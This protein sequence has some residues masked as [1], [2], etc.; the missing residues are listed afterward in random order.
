[1]TA[2]VLLCSVLGLLQPWN[3][4]E[5][6]TLLVIYGAVNA[7]DAYT[8]Q[9][10]TRSWIHPLICVAG[11]G[12]EF[13]EGLID[14]IAE[15]VVV[16]YRKLSLVEDI[17]SRTKTRDGRV[18]FV[19]SVSVPQEGIVAFQGIVKRILTSHMEEGQ[20][21]GKQIW[22]VGRGQGDLGEW[23]RTCERILRTLV[24]VAWSVSI[25]NGGR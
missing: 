19:A 9:L 24:G 20:K 16:D 10:A 18:S 5:G 2:A 1:M 4:P 25:G 22:P 7:V 12:V 13:V 17:P 21:A 6:K 23:L 3:K 8:V 15:D 14:R 11:N